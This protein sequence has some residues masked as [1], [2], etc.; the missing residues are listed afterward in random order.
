MDL[1]PYK[2]RGDQE[3]IVRQVSEAVRCG[4]PLVMESGTGTGKT[5]TSLTGAL[6]VVLGTGKKV[7]YLTR[8]KS[9]QRQVIHEVSLI[10][11][12]VDL[13]CIGLQGRSSGTCPMMAGDPEL[14]IGT[15]EE[16]SKLCS[17]YKKKDAGESSGCIY[18]DNME[19]CD[20][21]KY[22][23]YL[24]KEH[25][26]PEEFFSFCLQDLV[27]PYE[28]TK[29]LL[30]NADVV[31]IPY[32]FIFSPHVIRHFVD[33]MGIPLSNMVLIVDEA[34]N[35]PSY[36]REVMTVEYTTRALDLVEKEAKDW[37]DPEISKGFKVTDISAVFRECMEYAISEYIV[38][39]D[40]ILPYGFLQDE[41]MGRLGVS[42]LSL[43]SIYKGLI[44][45]GEI[46]VENKKSNRKLPRSYIRSFGDFMLSWNLCEE[47]TYVKLIVGGSNPRFEAFCLDP[48]EAA[49]PLRGCWA[50][51]SM[52]GT[53]TPLSDYSHELG[54]EDPIERVFVSPFPKENLRVLY[55]DDVSTNYEEINENQKT[56]S[57]MV[58]HVSGLIHSVNRNTAVFF[59]SY[60]L[61]DRMFN[62]C[63][64]TI[65]DRRIF[66]ERRGMAQSELMETVSNFRASEGSILF[67]VMGGRI[68]EGLD[69]P[70]KELEVAIIVG[71]P[72][73]KPTA[74][75]EALIRYCDYRFGNG[76]EHAVKVPAQ[77]K[78]R[79]AIGRLIRSET[80][81]GIAIMLDRRVSTMEGLGAI[82]TTEPVKEV[83]GFFR[84]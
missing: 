83:K 81:R 75:Q 36:L 17:E 23:E 77:R 55:V 71:I 66:V 2:Y 65:S 16:L 38:D 8:T 18:F 51:L 62:D 6:E 82:H 79:Q 74:K 35:L 9:Q 84:E 4:I 59:P 40:G 11:K 68:S 63:I 43:D 64:H 47:N 29:R 21:S 45:E 20:L 73:P 48:Y 61:M 12:N 60:N 27:C 26:Q 58:D 57:K 42:S 54:M 44:E 31:A 33:W 13:V 56:Y 1:F 46:I 5:V 39:E 7:I 24:K 28:L 15:S 14:A 22:I 49:E 80:D 3:E 50:S 52:S 78:M 30:Q 67:C 37:G 69:F 32:P 53:L 34:H 72:F 70:D 19:K 41:M 76:W 10:S 25:P